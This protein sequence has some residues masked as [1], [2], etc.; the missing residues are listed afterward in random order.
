MMETSIIFSLAARAPAAEYSYRAL[1]V[2]GD[3]PAHLLFSMPRHR[4]PSSIAT[5][6]AERPVNR[7]VTVDAIPLHLPFA[8]THA[9]RFTGGY[10]E[11]QHEYRELHTEETP[12]A[13]PVTKKVQKEVAGLALPGTTPQSIEIYYCFHL[14]AAAT[15]GKDTPGEKWGRTRPWPSGFRSTT[16]RLRPFG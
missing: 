7:F 6:I 14:S 15:R 11:M 5:S 10:Q 2:A 13:K 12:T 1:R 4:N 8:R 9:G 16:Y 3:T